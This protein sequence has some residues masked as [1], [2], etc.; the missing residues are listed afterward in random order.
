MEEELKAD[1]E[2]EWEKIESF[3]EKSMKAAFEKF[4]R[5]KLMPLRLSTLNCL[6]E[7]QL[8]ICDLRSTSEEKWADWERIDAV[9]RE[10]LEEDGKSLQYIKIKLNQQQDILEEI[11]LQLQQ[12]FQKPP[13]P[14]KKPVEAETGPSRVRP[15]YKPPSPDKP[16]R[17]I[18]PVSTKNFNDA[19]E[20]SEVEECPRPRANHIQE[21]NGG[22]RGG[23]R[24]RGR[25]LRV[26]SVPARARQPYPNDAPRCSP[27]SFP[28]TPEIVMANEFVKE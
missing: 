15:R 28:P 1:M 27:F 8:N 18:G 6:E 2:E 25:R 24:G 22:S 13:P 16:A 21:S 23:G 9:R 7:I 20:I 10:A 17:F 12:M 26:R 3:N 4:E 14:K 5:S 11:R 19:G